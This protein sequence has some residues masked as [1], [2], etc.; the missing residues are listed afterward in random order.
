MALEMG[1]CLASCSTSTS[2]S[3]STKSHKLLDVAYAYC[4]LFVVRSETNLLYSR[5]DCLESKFAQ[6]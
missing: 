5:N 2:T 4:M 3:T 1:C 6:P